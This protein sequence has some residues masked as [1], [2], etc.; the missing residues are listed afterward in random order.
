VPVSK[1]V[2]E[3]DDDIAH[4]PGIVVE[5]EF[6]YPAGLAVAGPDAVAV[7]VFETPQH[8]ITSRKKDITALALRLCIGI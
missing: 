5:I 4:N 2:A 3:I 7:Q 8:D 6:L 1:P